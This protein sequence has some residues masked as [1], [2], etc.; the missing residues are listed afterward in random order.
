MICSGQNGHFVVIRLEHVGNSLRIGAVI[1][2]NKRKRTLF[3][4]ASAVRCLLE[5]VE[6][7]R[8]VL[9]NDLGQYDWKLNKRHHVEQNSRSEDK[10][11]EAQ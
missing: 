4:D 9:L 10:R 7:I 1:T 11:N 8:A 2:H 6:A 5:L 3:N